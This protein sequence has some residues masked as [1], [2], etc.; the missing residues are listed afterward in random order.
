MLTLSHSLQ[1]T[2]YEKYPKMCKQ[3][4]EKISYEK[5]KNNFC[6]S[7]CAATYNN[8][9]TPKRKMQKTC[10]HCKSLIPNQY[11]YCQSCISD[12]KHL[13]GKKAIKDKT[14]S[15]IMYGNKRA[16]VYGAVR[17]HA[18]YVLKER[19]NVCEKCGYNKHVEV[20]HKKPIFAFEPSTLISKINDSSNLIL[21]CP[22]CHW[23]FDNIKI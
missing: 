15:E 12:N 4:Q 11:T 23:E 17:H 1:K 7:S 18:K 20:C 22:N 3:C 13:R 9:K 16:S 10:K 21:L 5:R 8:L 2:N 6:N 14:L 19:V